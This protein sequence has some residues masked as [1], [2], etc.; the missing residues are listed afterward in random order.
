MVKSE[1]G[2]FREGTTQQNFSKKK[3]KTLRGILIMKLMSLSIPLLKEKLFLNKL[4]KLIS[5]NIPFVKTNA[6]IATDIK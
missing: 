4:S 1:S 5:S 2:V 3:Q 6:L